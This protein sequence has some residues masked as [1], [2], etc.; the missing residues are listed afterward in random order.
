MNCSWASECLNLLWPHCLQ[1]M[2]CSS[3]THSFYTLSELQCGLS[4]FLDELD[5]S[6]SGPGAQLHPTVEKLILPWSGIETSWT[7]PVGSIRQTCTEPSPGA[8]LLS[9][10]P[11]E[12][13]D[14]TVQLGDQLLNYITE[15]VYIEVCVFVCLSLCTP[16]CICACVCVCIRV[17]MHACG[18][19][20]CLSSPTT[21]FYNRW[22][23]SHWCHQ[24]CSC[25]LMEYSLPTL[26][27]LIITISINCT[28]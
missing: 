25:N 20:V 27:G 14:L 15:T 1:I 28:L 9:P 22:L 6:Y 17:Y 5:G 3:F 24:V 12:K 8:L 2:I 13:F 21:V 18:V 10:A 26:T 4:R 19:H 11:G 23:M 16:V 7:E